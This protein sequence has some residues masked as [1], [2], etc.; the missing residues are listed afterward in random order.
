[1]IRKRRKFT[2]QNTTGKRSATIK[3]GQ[4]TP[5]HMFRFIFFFDPS[6]V[7]TLKTN[8]SKFQDCWNFVQI[9][10][11]DQRDSR[12]D[13]MMTISEFT[14]LYYDSHPIFD[15]KCQNA[16]LGPWT[17]IRQ[18]WAGYKKRYGCWPVPKL[19]YWVESCNIKNWCQIQPKA[20]NRVV[21]ECHG[22]L[23]TFFHLISIVALII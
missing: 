7:L 22:S 8:K 14:E 2:C 16:G 23:L 10:E 15:A 3:M 5:G 1:M 12:G 17:I 19:S 21:I 9:N 13:N 6:Q 4:L 18:D 11:N 20:K